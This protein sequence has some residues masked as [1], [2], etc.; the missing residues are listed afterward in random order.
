MTSK[1]ASR[2]A[3]TDAVVAAIT[4]SHIPTVAG[5]LRAVEDGDP[6]A[7]AVLEALAARARRC[8]VIGITGAAG[9]GKST[10][11]AALVG[12]LRARDALVGVLAVDPSSR[13]TGGALLG[14]RLRM[15]EHADDPRVFIRSLASRGAA[16][17][18]AS[19]TAAMILVLE[20]MG[21]DAIIVETLGTG[22]DETTIS[23]VADTT[24][25]VAMPGAGDEVQA[26]KAGSIEEADLFV[27]N[28]A[29]RGDANA[30]V[31]RLRA[32]LR[33]IGQRA[34][35]P[36]MRTVAT[37]GDGVDALLAQL[38]KAW[39]RAAAPRPEA[40]GRALIHAASLA[41]V[42]GALVGW[43]SGDPRGRALAA[44]VGRGAMSADAAAREGLAALAG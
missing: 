30:A 40:R 33:L 36:V 31:A 35:R 17:G 20:A 15:A 22:Q 43:L 34:S 1:G 42:E 9:V 32:I 16:G 26:M 5:V 28:K 13:R 12:A 38:D 27:I 37:T 41:M 14:D 44:R 29:D 8:H 10:L 39:S 6:G 4:A 19:A 7:A 24:V 25:L 2:L 18:I 21:C 11:V 3:D 23:R